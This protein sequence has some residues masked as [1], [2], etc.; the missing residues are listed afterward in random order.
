MTGFLIVV[1]LFLMAVVVVGIR[2]DRRHRGI[3][4]ESRRAKGSPRLDNQTRA[5]QVGWS[6][7][8]RVQ[9]RERTWACREVSGRPPKRATAV[10]EVVKREGGPSRAASLGQSGVPA[11]CGDPDS[12]RVRAAPL[13]HHRWPEGAGPSAN[14]CPRCPPQLVHAASRRGTSILKSVRMPAASGVAGVVKLGHPVPESNWSWAR[15]S[16]ALQP[17]HR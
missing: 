6:R 10:T 14:T 15:N 9:S 17:V 2:Y 7:L 5:R 12:S 3:G 11:A 13:M 8:L 4:S 1:S 16:S